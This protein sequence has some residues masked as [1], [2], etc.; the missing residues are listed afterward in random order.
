[1]KN[2]KITL[3]RPAPYLLILLLAVCISSCTTGTRLLNRIPVNSLEVK[4]VDQN[5]E[6]IQGA[7]I[8]ASN[9]RQNTTDK[10]GIAEIR[11]GS[12]GLFSVSVLAD[13]HLPSNFMV[14]M[15]VDDGT[16]IT[17]R[18]TGEL[19]FAGIRFG[20]MSIYPL[21]FNYMFSSF[22]YAVTLHPY[23]EGEYTVWKMTMDGDESILTM[24][25]AFL[26]TNDKGQQWWRIQIMT[27]DDEQSSYMAEILFSKDRKQILRFR[28]K[29]GDG[30][31][32]E[33]PVTEGWYSKPMQLTE[34]SMEGAVTKKGISVTVPA[35]DF[36]ADLL[37]F[38]STPA[39]SLKLW[40][41]SDIQAVPG[42]VAKFT[43]ISEDSPIYTS[44]LTKFGSGAETMLGSY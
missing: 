17:R 9:G 18:L 26:K 43:A 40:K 42:G 6:P 24:H 3:A 21:L 23:D 1:M 2:M 20:S 14:T 38:G 4:V 8:M 37:I 13:N 16:T 11:F 31:V 22:G 28:E 33:K 7:Q 30:E 39:T 15:P 10:N 29:I 19:N 27:G 44:V 36:K 34:E 41:T 35:G 5:G 25:K 12:V 32:R